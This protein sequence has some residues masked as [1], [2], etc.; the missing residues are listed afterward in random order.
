MRRRCIS[1]GAWLIHP[2][3][4]WSVN[5]PVQFAGLVSSGLYQLNVEIPAVTSG[6]QPIQASVS[7]F[8]TVPNVSIS[9]ASH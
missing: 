1:T 3:L 8:Q 7:G 9:V 6:D 4:P 2:I 5:A